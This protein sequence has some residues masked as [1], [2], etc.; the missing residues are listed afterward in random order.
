MTKATS[1]NVSNIRKD[2][3][4]ASISCQ[5]VTRIVSKDIKAEADMVNRYARGLAFIL[6]RKTNNSV[7]TDDICQETWRIVLEKIRS[8]ALKDPSKLSAYIIQIGKNQLLMYYRSSQQKRMTLNSDV[9]VLVDEGQQPQQALESYQL[10]LLVRK[11]IT[12]LNSSRDK[13]IIT[14][15]Y[16]QQ[17]EKLNICQDLQL[18]ELHFNRVLY[19]ARQRF[20][21]LW[22]AH[23]KLTG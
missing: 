12:E 11:L 2:E 7:L 18:T 15:F 1:T 21:E 13:E 23:T 6:Q 10:T 19:R 16:V 9:N 8:G 4:E 14:R 3:T 20:K 17:E 5:L 22:L